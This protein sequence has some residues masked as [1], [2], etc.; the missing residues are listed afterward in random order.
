MKRIKLLF[1]LLLFAGSV[2]LGQTVQITGTVTSSE[3]GIPMPGVFVSAK[4][5][6]IGAITG[7][8]GKYVVSVPSSV[9]TL[10]FSF[11]GYKSQELPVSGKTKIDVTLAPD[12]FNVDEVVV[13]A[14]G[15]AKKGS[16]T[17]SAAQIST[18][19]I[20][21][22]PIS[23]VMNAVE[24][25]N[26]GIQVTSASG[27]PGSGQSIRIRG[28]GSV[29]ASN[30]PLYVVDGVPYS[31]TIANLNSNDIDNI[32]I[33]KDAAS[34]A[35]YGNRAANG[36]VLIT[37]KRGSR[38]KSSISFIVSQGVSSR[39]IPE[40]ERVSADQ[41]YPLMW[42]ANRNSLLVFPTTTAAGFP[43][44]A[45]YATA[46][47]SATTN[48]KSIVGY[49]LYNVADTAIVR[50]N[51][52]LNPNA[53]M[54]GTYAEDLDWQKDIIKKG[55]RKEYGLSFNGGAEKSDYYVSVGYL[56][57]KGYTIKSDYERYTGRI[58]VNTQPKKW[59]K[60]GLNL[61]GTMTK[62]NV[63]S[64][65]GTSY[66][67][68]FFFSRNMG[69]IYPVYAH[70]PTTGAYLTDAATGGK[71]FD[72]GNLVGLPARPAGA[73]T[74]RHVVA[75]TMWND[76][77][78][79]RNVLSARTYLDIYFL[80]DF[81]FTVNLSSDVSSYNFG[82]Y[83]NKIVGD[84]APAGRGSKTNSL[85]NNVTINQL[86]NYNKTFG[87]HNVEVLLGHENYDYTY[88]Y[89][90]A[91][92]QGQ[93][94]DGITELVNFTT[95][96][97]LT[98]YIDKYRT[99]GFFSRFNY[100]FD[101]K[102]LFSASYR[103]D[104]SSEFYKANRWGNFW[105]VSGAWRLDQENFIKNLSF[106]DMMK[107]RASY[108][109]VGNDA[110][111]GYYAWQAL[112]NIGPGY[113]NAL[114]PGSLQSS[115][116]NR[117]ISWESNN[118]YDLALEFGLFK[119]I[120][121]SVEVY[122]RVS[123]NLLFNVP[124][125]ISSG[126]T[127]QWKNIGAMYNQGIEVRISGDVVKNKNFSWNVDLN[128][129]TYK[130]EITKLPDGQ[131]EIISGTK[132]LMVGHSV[133]DFW[134][135]DWYGVDPADGAALF[136]ANI[137]DTATQKTNLRF[138]GTDTVSISQNNAKYH[139]AGSAIP[140]LIGGITNTI[141]YKGFELNVLATFG[142]GGLIYDGTAWGGLM[143]SGTYGNALSTDILRR[144][145]K[146]G[147]ITDVPRLDV[148]KNTV[149]SSGSDRYLTDASYFAIKSVTFGYS[150]PRS[151]AQKLQVQSARIY[152]S[153]ENLFLINARKGMD[154]Q[155]NFSGTTDNVY[156]PSRILTVGINVTL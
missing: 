64:S 84:G 53:K 117:S 39:S 17:G 148:S 138:F 119:R 49:N 107:L 36:V 100:T 87:K 8:D 30:D 11:V 23:N 7:T 108:G 75:E 10:V 146:P 93:I 99:E 152:F 143:S 62:S 51:G 110:G 128:L 132:K 140:D 122:R 9:Q 74:G 96:N 150:L 101:N 27:Q 26:P 37:T 31:G 3:D 48:L 43:T 118:T 131:T 33:L 72:L 28:I 98:S 5:T 137:R 35:L 76:N 104:G 2:A 65:G 57:E 130:N 147:D 114:E 13:V 81:K 105:S 127:S 66:V 34:A 126:I 18:E 113:N 82:S 15:T 155:G 60:T 73:S 19:K 61:S 44:A 94:V 102:Y 41:Y 54:L 112:Y 116:S 97:S 25:I 21:A 120:Q 156:S 12:V 153:G 111:V 139:Y 85:T 145:Q 91:S 69:P 47:Q 16:F 135:R 103:R 142:I 68:P 78:Y 22:R 109:A 14:Y 67:N 77:L 4:G 115:L 46:N 95:T 136:S 149:F 55:S 6:T 106:I 29:S 63:A 59:I 79:A 50:P 40:Y 32:S 1:W 71:V 38:E 20:A 124:L 70:N 144:W 83:T 123:T 45:A 125:P 133:Y 141:S 129:S 92:R 90:A 121:G 151:L 56:N 134:L 58:N 86:L 42:E 24:G 88:N 80:K 154:P 52:I 89:F